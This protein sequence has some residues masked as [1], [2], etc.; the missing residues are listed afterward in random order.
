M[1]T[2]VPEANASQRLLGESSA[3]LR[4]FL[5]WRSAN[6]YT[7]PFA[8]KSFLSENKFF[9]VTF[10]NVSAQHHGLVGCLDL[11]NLGGTNLAPGCVNMLVCF[12]LITLRIVY[13]IFFP[14]IVALQVFKFIY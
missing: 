6:K 4:G 12:L 3:W 5:G 14:P 1:C 11:L 2:V 7:A 13:F 8:Q 10:P 9:A